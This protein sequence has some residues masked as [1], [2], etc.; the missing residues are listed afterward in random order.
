M[1]FVPSAGCT[2]DGLEWRAGGETFSGRGRHWFTRRT[3]VRRRH[4]RE[5]GETTRKP[6]KGETSEAACT[7][8]GVNTLSSPSILVQFV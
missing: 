5:T 6:E 7:F 1:S 3:G 2:S 4:G 8:G